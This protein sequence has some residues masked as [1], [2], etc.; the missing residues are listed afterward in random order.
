MKTID[1][2]IVPE[3]ENCGKNGIPVGLSGGRSKTVGGGGHIRSGNGVCAL[4]FSVSSTYVES[5]LKSSGGG[6]KIFSI[7]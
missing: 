6:I 7:F 1:F 4:L 5:E 2:G 3:H